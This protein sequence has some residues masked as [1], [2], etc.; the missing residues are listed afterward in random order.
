MK[1]NPGTPLERLLL[2]KKEVRR[3][4]RVQEQRLSDDWLYIRNNAGHLL[5]SEL[6]TTLWRTRKVN[7]PKSEKSGVRGLAAMVWKMARPFVWRWVAGVGWRV[8]RN[9][10][11]RKREE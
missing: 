5:V 3:L 6:M 8:F 11:V 4:C 1:T 7:S 10:F 2:E 9:M